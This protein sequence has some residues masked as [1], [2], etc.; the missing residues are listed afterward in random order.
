MIKENLRIKENI[1]FQDK[2]NAINEILES[3][4]VDGNYTPYYQRHGEIVGIAFNFLEGVEFEDDDN[5][6][7]L[8]DS[9]VEL[10]EKV[11]E[12]LFD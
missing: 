7:E 4:F 5:I 8:Y 10:K 3:N 6:F 1:T 12:V 11:D 2:K 9:N